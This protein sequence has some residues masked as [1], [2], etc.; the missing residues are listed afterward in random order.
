MANET[1]ARKILVVDDDPDVVSYLEIVLR[2]NGFEPVCALD[3]GRVLELAHQHRPDVICLDIAMPEPSGVKVYRQ[4]RA[5]PD[6]R[7]IPVVMITGV[8]KEFKDFIH[9]R[10]YV[11]PP[12][13]YIA[14]PFEIEE[15]LD[16]LERVLGAGV[17]AQ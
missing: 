10:K 3:G 15:L 14:K 12:D 13:G 6:L 9:H 16:T 11:P 1:R 5:D 7:A 2:D 17:V 8:Q 4:L